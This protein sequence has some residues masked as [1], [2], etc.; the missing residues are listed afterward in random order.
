MTSKEIYAVRAE[1]DGMSARLGRLQWVKR[2]A[3]RDTSPG[4]CERRNNLIAEDRWNEDVCERWRSINRAFHA[5]IHEAADNSYLSRSIH[6]T[7]EI[8]FFA[9]IRFKW[10]DKEMLQRSQ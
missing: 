8:P 1:L 9:L 4:F 5:V 2:P 3:T 6:Q 10:Y 7:D